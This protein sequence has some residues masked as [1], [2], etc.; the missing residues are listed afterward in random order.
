MPALRA[1]LKDQNDE[2]KRAAI[3]GLGEWP[4]IAPV[5]DLFETARGA[6]S[7]AHQVLAVRSAIH[8]IGLSAPN[9]PHS[10][11]AKLVIEAMNLAKE[12]AEKRAILALLPRYPVKETLDLATS[13]S[14]DPQVGAEAKAAATRLERTIRR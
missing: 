4:D 11:S 6:V 14:N 12:A 3:V 9:R 8:L 13:L 2:V 5:A 1:A 7:P 10:E